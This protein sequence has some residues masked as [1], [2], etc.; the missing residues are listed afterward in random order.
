MT[1]K[2][3]TAII[4]WPVGKYNAQGE[5]NLCSNKT[6]N[7]WGINLTNYVLVLYKENLKTNDEHK[8]RLINKIIHPVF[9]IGRQCHKN[10]NS[11]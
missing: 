10:V 7:S 11:P 8:T 9:W 6:A 3:S 4:Q 5:K 1:Y 2:K